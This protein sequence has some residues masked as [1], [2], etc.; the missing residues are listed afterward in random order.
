MAG[1]RIVG[2][3]GATGFVGRHIVRELLSRG[4]SVR[5]LVRSREKAREVLP[6]DERLKLIVGEPTAPDSAAG[7]CA[8]ASAVINTVGI[9]RE[10][11]GNTFRKAHVLTT[12]SLVEAAE[13]AGVRGFVQISA[14]GVGDEGTTQYQRTKFEAEQIVRRS[15][16]LWTIL[17]PGLVHGADSELLRTAKGWVTGSKQPWFFLPYFT[18]VETVSDVPLGPVRRLPGTVQPVWSAVTNSKS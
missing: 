6:R 7:L 2:V 11:A 4:W 18:R 16:L 15:G 14:I 9:L 5:G 3:A 1:E 13:I 8:G 12:R 17:R 10:T